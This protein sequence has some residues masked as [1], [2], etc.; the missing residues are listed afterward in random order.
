MEFQRIKLA[1]DMFCNRTIF[2]GYLRTGC[3]G[4]FGVLVDPRTGPMFF[5]PKTNGHRGSFAA[6][7]RFSRRP[8]LRSF[9]IFHPFGHG[10]H[11]DEGHVEGGMAPFQ[12]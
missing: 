5:P 8:L 6:R 4:M 9:A 7:A 12:G 3:L 10:Q 11:G 1:Q 2:A